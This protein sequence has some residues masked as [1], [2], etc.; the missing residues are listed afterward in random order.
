MEQTTVKGGTDDVRNVQQTDTTSE[1]AFDNVE[2]QTI[3][4]DISSYY[5]LDVVY[6]SR[7]VKASAPAFPLGQEC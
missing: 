1:K 4:N 3:L 7:S 5:Q 6:H 2:L